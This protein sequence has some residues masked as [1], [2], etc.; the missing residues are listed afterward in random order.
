MFD[1]NLRSV[2]VL[3]RLVVPYLEKRKGNIINMSGGSG[4][5]PL[6]KAMAHSMAK[7]A[8]NMFTKCMALELAP[9]GIRVNCVSPSVIRTELVET[10]LGDKWIEFEKLCATIYPMRRIGE[11]VDVADAVTFL[12]SSQSA[13]F[14]TG[15]IFPVDG[16]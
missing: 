16:G 3:T 7:N 11:P 10:S 5:R 1:I 4:E 6:P 15:C 13:S 2:Q 14:I 8:L 12:A 9:K